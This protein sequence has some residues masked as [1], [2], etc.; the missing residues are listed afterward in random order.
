V[1]RLA[2]KSFTHA[3]ILESSPCNPSSA[4]LEFLMK[5]I[6]PMAASPNLRSRHH[7]MSR[8]MLLPRFWTGLL[9]V[10][11]CA[12][13]CHLAAQQAE[14]SRDFFLQPF[15]A[16][17]PWNTPVGKNAVYQPIKGIEKYPGSI[18]YE[19]HW[20]TGFYKATIHDRAACLYLHD[21][22]LWSKI[23][24][25]QVRT[26]EN[27]PDVEDALRRAGYLQ[28]KFPANYY[29]TIVRSPPGQRTLP[30]NVRPVLTGWQ[31]AIYMPADAAS[32][33]D[34][35]AH[36][37]VMQPNG[38][39]LECYDAVVCRNGDVVCTMAGFTD[40]SGDG[41]GA[42]N[43][44]CASLLNNYAGLIRKGEVTQGKIPHALSCL[45]SRR[46]LAP[47]FVWPA[48]AF[49][50]NDRYEGTLP[51][52]ALLAIPSQVQLNKLGL[53]K[54]GLVIA[55]AA[56]EYGIY[57]VDRGG[58]G[59]ITIKAALDAEDAM[60]ADSW[61]DAGIIIKCLQQVE[62]NGAESIGGGVP[63]R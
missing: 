54:K 49:D 53:S 47:R 18:N 15:S 59:G 11:L 56:Q 41:T 43:G 22:I 62:N 34:S 2:D 27:S 1:I 38:L 52:G 25:G 7:R 4:D 33:P 32:S 63:R 35:D 48:S 29:S 21:C 58:D 46:L 20:T 61:K 10:F 17:S 31:N 42:N 45:M 51:M 26:K 16:G 36:L 12:P 19:G 9:A 55:R 13:L 50:M 14:A 3:K 8:A 37:A 24:S 28:P 40:P 57:V 5:P 60:Y 6:F 30:S 44:R 39:V 23:S